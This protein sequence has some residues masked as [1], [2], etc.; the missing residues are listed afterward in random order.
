M[1]QA[2]AGW[3]LTEGRLNINADYLYDITRI[4][5]PDTP[6]VAWPVYVGAGARLRLGAEGEGEGLGVRV[7]VGMRL[8]PEDL[9]LDVYLEVAPVLLLLPETTVTFDAGLGARFYF[10]KG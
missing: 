5:T 10:G 4:E 9:R 2:A 1:I 6:G 3:S 8:E 7:P